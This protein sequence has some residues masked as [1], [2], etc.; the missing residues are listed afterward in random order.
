MRVPKLSNKY[1][2]FYLYDIE[3]LV[4][5]FDR[6]LTFVENKL[7]EVVDKVDYLDDKV[8]YLDDKV[9]YLDDKV[10]YVQRQMT[11]IRC[12]KPDTFAICDVP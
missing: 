8:D 1:K 6:R 3:M 5:S 4:L 12:K 11:E 10:A 9:D 7:H 2:D